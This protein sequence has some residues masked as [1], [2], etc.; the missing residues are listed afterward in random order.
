LLEW[1]VGVDL[2]ME[3]DGWRILAR[4]IAERLEAGKPGSVVRIVAAHF[5]RPYPLLATVQIEL[6]TVW[7]AGLPG[8]GYGRLSYD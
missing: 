7:G 4:D 8:A 1:H 2:A 5:L 6:A 3:Q